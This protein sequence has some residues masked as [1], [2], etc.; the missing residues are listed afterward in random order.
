M[1]HGPQ[2]A[3]HRTTESA[4]LPFAPAGFF[5][6]LGELGQVQRE[7]GAGWR[8]RERFSLAGQ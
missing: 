2:L 5:S 1:L 4:L 3:W 6:S 8:H 7:L